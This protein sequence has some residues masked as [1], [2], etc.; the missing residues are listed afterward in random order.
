MFTYFRKK[1]LEEVLDKN[2]YGKKFKKISDE[3]YEEYTERR[4]SLVSPAFDWE[5]DDQGDE[6]GSRIGDKVRA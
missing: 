3:M 4:M 5:N 2:F 1:A 6:A